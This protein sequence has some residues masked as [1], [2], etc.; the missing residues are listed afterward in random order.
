ME[1]NLYKLILKQFAEILSQMPIT[2]QFIIIVIV[3]YTFLFIK[4]Q[5]FRRYTIVFFS[6][7]FKFLSNR[8]ILNHEFFYYRQ[9]YRKQINR[10]NFE[11]E[12]DKT[13]LYGI[14]LNSQVDASID[15]THDFL[16]NKMEELKKLNIVE[17]SSAILKNTTKIIDTYEAMILEEFTDL[18]GTEKAADLYNL[19]YTAFYI[20]HK[21]RID[22]IDEYISELHH[23][24]KD[25]EDFIHDYLSLLHISTT[26]AIADLERAMRDVNGQIKRIIYS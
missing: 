13:E 23:F 3:A 10:I 4:N 24:S 12:E 9:F 5:K 2:L 11:G 19:I 25:K 17:F 6:R 22:M 7:L 26:L 14:V 16:D 20:Y 8:S 18:H 21:P 15:V 1:E